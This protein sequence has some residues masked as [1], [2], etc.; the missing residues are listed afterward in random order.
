MAFDSL[1][2]K[3]Q[4]VFKNLRSKGKLTEDDVKA[5]LKA[6]LDKAKD[7]ATLKDMFSKSG[8]AEELGMSYDD[9][10]SQ[11][12]DSMDSLFASDNLDETATLMILRALALK[13]TVRVQLFTPFLRTTLWLLI[14]ALTW[15]VRAV[16]HS[17]VLQI[18]LTVLQMAS[19]Q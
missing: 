17:R 3:L 18:L 11:Y 7:D 19:S 2:E 9:I 6:V 13:K 15:A 4:N 5:A 8:V 14:L 12:A 16:H 10:I 1:S